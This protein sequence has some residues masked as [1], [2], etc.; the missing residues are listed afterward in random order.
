MPIVNP[1]AKTKKRKLP[2]ASV[3]ETATAS[4]GFKDRIATDDIPIPAQ[5]YATF[6]QAFPRESDEIRNHYD[7]TSSSTTGNFNGN[8]ND[9]A[10]DKTTATANDSLLT[11]R[12][13]HVLLQQPHVLYVSNKQKG[14]GVLNYIRNVPYQ[15]SRMVPDYV[16]STT[17][18][19]LFLSV[20]YHCL[21]PQYIHRR[22]AEL[23]TD[24]T[25]RVLMVLVDVEDNANTLLELNK[26]AVVHNMTLILA[27]SEQEA[28]RYLETIKAFDGKDATLIQRKE[29]VDFVDQVSDFLCTCKS[30]SKTDSQQL[31]T[32]FGTVKALAKASVDELAFVHGMGQV[33][34]R[35]L[36]NALH[37]P[38][39]KRRA[40]ARAKAKEESLREQ[41]D[42]DQKQQLQQEESPQLEGEKKEFE[43]AQEGVSGDE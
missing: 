22:I 26:L 15:F 33:K 11:D 19:A 30:V 27:W 5:R 10:A 25:L 16:M 20:K 13:H 41:E 12:D 21:Y 4:R 18:C 14:N 37:K 38:F 6:S 17:R 24:F 36:H 29:Q 9:E 34:V 28:A 42:E 40:K 1:Y 32:A 31:L 23:K 43:G 35:R 3:A 8:A 39:S 7:E 2:E